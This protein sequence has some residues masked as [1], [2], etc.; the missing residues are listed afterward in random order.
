MAGAAAT[1]LAPVRED[2]CGDDVSPQPVTGSVA[3]R[4][5]GLR[6]RFPDGTDVL[7]GV[8]IDIH[9]G[10]SVALIGANGTGKSTLLRCC[11]RLIEPTAGSVNLLGEPVT[12]LKPR[13]LRS[14]RSRI[15]FVFQKHN[16]VPR[17]S[18]LS[19]VIHGAQARGGGLRTWYQSLA[20]AETRAQAMHCLHRVGLAD[21]A[22]RRADRLSGGQS[23][24]V[25]IARALMQQPEFVMADE[26][27][28]SLDPAAGE[29]VMQLFVDLLKEDGITLL[30][31]SHNLR[32]ALEYAGRVIALKQGNVVVDA[33]TAG[34]DAE[35]LGH[36]YE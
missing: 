18:A 24:R 27:V 31:T 14:L 5:K 11:I 16:L 8:D 15:G 2:G 21:I 30:Y 9:E 34:V 36:I 28:A 19:N 35:S 23:Q 20:P 1:A 7:K 17:L 33:A 25:A 29:E 22:D 6:K 10:Q 13:A 4:I 3:C 12:S 26:P 32:H